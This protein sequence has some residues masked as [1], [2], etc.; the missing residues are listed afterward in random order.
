MLRRAEERSEEK[1]S[2][3]IGVDDWA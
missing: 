3:I 2:D 1:C